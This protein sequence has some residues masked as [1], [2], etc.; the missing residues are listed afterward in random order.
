MGTDVSPQG[1]ARGRFAQ[2]LAGW[3]SSTAGAELWRG[4]AVRGERE[5]G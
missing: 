4:R 1:E 3:M 5:R 2:L